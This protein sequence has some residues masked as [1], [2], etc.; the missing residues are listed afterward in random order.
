MSRGGKTRGRAALQVVE[1]FVVWDGGR[2]FEVLA[3]VAE[4]V[5]NPRNRKVIAE[6]ATVVAQVIFMMDRLNMLLQDLSYGL[7]K[8]NHFK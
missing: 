1:E 8:V 4:T 2:I 5:V 6:M 7:E 3:E